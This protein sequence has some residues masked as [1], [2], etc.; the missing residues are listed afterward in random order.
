M[1]NSPFWWVLIVFM[2]VLDIYVFQAL[3]VIAPA[4]GS[5]Y[6][7]LVIY[8]Y[9]ILSVAALLTLLILPYLHF[10]NQAKL[11]KSTIFALVAGLF[12][13]KLVAALFFVIDDLRR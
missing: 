6:R 9:W 4:P 10:E 8:G 12:F 13:A 1:R 11:A 2:V 3:K 7:P 5:R